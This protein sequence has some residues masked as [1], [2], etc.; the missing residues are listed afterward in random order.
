[1]DDR[2][3]PPPPSRLP[4]RYLWLPVAYRFQVL[5]VLLAIAAFVVVYAVCVAAACLSLG[6]LFRIV[7]APGEMWVIWAAWAIAVVANVLV[8]LFLAKGVLVRS[9]RRKEEWIEVTA[10][11]EPVLFELL[12][13]LAREIGA[14]VPRRVFLSRGVEAAV[15][16]ETTLLSLIIP[17]R[18]QLVIGLGLLNVL[19]LRE[20]KAV[21]AHELGHFSQS[22]MRLGSYV[23][24]ATRILEELVH[25]R[26]DVDV[27][28]DTLRFSPRRPMQM[29]GW[30]AYGI[31]AFLRAILSFLH[32]TV[33]LSFLAL[34]REME[35]AADRCAVAAAGSDAIAR[36]L[37]RAA[38]GDEALAL[39]ARGL[40]HAADHGLY[41]SDVYAHQ[42]RAIE[43]V[44]AE[45]SRPE[46]SA[47]DRD[48]G[49]PL[50]TRERDTRPSMWST[51]P[52]DWMREER[53]R[54]PYVEVPRLA[55]D[56]GSP[57][58]L[59]ADPDA[60]RQRVSM[61]MARDSHPG[62]AIRFT[63]PDTVERFLEQE[64]EDAKLDAKHSGVYSK[65]AIAQLDV[66]HAFEQAGR[67]ADG[68]SEI[69]AKWQALYGPELASRGARLEALHD[70]LE[71]IR[72]AS[73]R[74]QT[75]GDTTFSFRGFPRSVHE[76]RDLAQQVEAE[77]E[78]EEKWHVGWDARV[79][80]VHARM[81]LDLDGPYPDDLR[82]RYDF[83]LAI[84]SLVEE[85]LDVGRVLSP[86]I[87]A[88][89][90]DIAVGPD[91]EAWVAGAA[92]DARA[93]LA[94]AIERART[95]RAPEL[96]HL[97]LAR[98]LAHF[99]LPEP[100]VSDPKLL[101]STLDGRLVRR[102]AS[103]HADALDRTERVRKKSLAA[104][105]AKQEAISAR[106]RRINVRAPEAA[107]AP[108]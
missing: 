49:G 45:A 52:P 34:S 92:L 20:L 36:A 41:T 66:A 78:A 55:S 35:F 73:V 85:L 81:A 107:A 40:A 91:A 32:G 12:A 38:L 4:S 79:L 104:L 8:V 1:M 71:A 94:A 65:R 17:P 76:V 100:V 28:I 44:R 23:Y 103:Q 97:D 93:L 90:T 46:W 87:A 50:F 27:T 98:G 105:L 43:L 48:A 30:T 88:S 10:A 7:P 68:A 47:L 14:P 25:G 80:E 21:L 15:F 75:E 42:A 64:R 2:L 29:A 56:R 99:L 37:A 39:A 67:R 11:R 53:A 51:H 86:A 102:L 106:W 5:G 13:R 101:G 57:W 83:H 77:L 9:R 84:Q 59:L 108:A 96:P 69:E 16:Q 63:D 95:F 22:S 18:K 3:Y 72:V 6:L 54:S 70:D 19:E 33:R 60:L 31:V 62:K 58:R 61:Q 26:D 89:E 24:F 82:E 74:A